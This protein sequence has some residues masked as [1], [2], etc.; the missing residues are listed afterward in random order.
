M[1]AIEFYRYG[2]P[3]VLQYVE[4]AKPEPQDD[5][6]LVR[7]HAAAANPLDWH[8]MRANPFL[9]RLGGGLTKPKNP[10]IGADF[11]G[12]V[13]AVGKHVTRFKVGDAVFGSV[14]AG[15]FAEYVIAPEGNLALKP[16]NV[17]FEQ[18]AAVPVV[19]LT[20]L[21]S[22]RKADIQS[23]QQVL[24]N[25]ASGGV[26][27]AAVQIAKSFGAEVTAVCSTRNLEVVRGIGADH[28]I[29]YTAEDF[30]QHASR[31]DL[32]CDCIGNVSYFGLRRALKPN[33]SAIVV[34]FTSLSGL[35][36]KAILS[37]SLPI[38]ENR[39]VGFLGVA[40]VD[41]D[42]LEAIKDLLEAGKL[43]PVID[44]TY[45]LSQTADAIRH[46]ETLR[47]RGKVI[48]TVS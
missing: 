47:A 8:L 31:Y 44:R 17:S 21:Q 39:K 34:G 46:L 3:D 16:A 7:V 30:S 22:L 45:P 26:G 10:K 4:T 18:A 19:A 25:G 33:G 43:V 12:E 35:F 1:K 15:A 28:V 32:I 24:I 6:I 13:E 37:M 11:A 42:D 27:T 29:D 14:G 5:Q 36:L 48:I 40:K 2:S 41:S 20:A 23:D 38:K 9:V